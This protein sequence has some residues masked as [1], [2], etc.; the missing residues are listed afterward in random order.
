MTNNHI[1]SKVTIKVLKM[2]FF[3]CSIYFLLMGFGLI[4]YPYLLLKSTVGAEVNPTI[5][6]MLRGAG[7][8]ILPYSLLYIIVAKNP[9]KQKWGLYII[10][11]ANSIAII[12]DLG[13]VIMNE[14][15]LGYA[16]IDVPVEVISLAG[17]LFILIKIRFLKEDSER[18][19]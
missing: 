12:L 8:S 3:C 15:K 5:I 4:F 7:G 6:G 13:S 18:S 17:V 10:G 11:L 16:M 1:F 2:I 14:Y 9:L 19:F